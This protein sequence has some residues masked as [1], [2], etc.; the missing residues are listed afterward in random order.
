MQRRP[1]PR[2]V[3]A[4]GP[5]ARHA[6]PARH[7]PP[8]GRS[9]ARPGSAA[10]R[11][12]RARVR[13]TAA[14]APG[15]RGSGERS[16]ARAAGGQHSSGNAVSLTI[17]RWARVRTSGPGSH[18]RARS[19]QSSGWPWPTS[20]ASPPGTS[21]AARRDRS[22]RC[23]TAAGAVERHLPAAIGPAAPDRRVDADLLA[24]RVE[25]RAGRQ[26]E[27]AVGAR[28]DPLGPPR[29]GRRRRRSRPSGA[30]RRASSPDDP[31]TRRRAPTG[32]SRRACPSAS[33]RAR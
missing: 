32:R 23:V 30:G 2:R 31:A 25:H 7:V 17:R 4:A 12:P 10:R 5:S 15:R 20:T 29:E 6:H 26:A 9:V 28:L 19:A 24:G 14:S 8:R 27:R 16:S 22:R 13:T 11:R 33:G 3:A 21:R 18:E 1:R